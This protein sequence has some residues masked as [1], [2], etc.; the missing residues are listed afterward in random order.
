[1]KNYPKIKS[2][3]HRKHIGEAMAKKVWQVII[4]DKDGTKQTIQTKNLT[5]WCKENN[6]DNSNL[7]KTLIYEN[8]KVHNKDKTLS[9]SLLSNITVSKTLALVT[10]SKTSVPITVSKNPTVS[11]TPK[12]SPVTVS[13]STDPMITSRD[14]EDDIEDTKEY[15]RLD[16]AIDSIMDNAERTISKREIKEYVENLTGDLEWYDKDSWL[17]WLKVN[18]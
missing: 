8:R 5:E 14:E 13:R 18:L 1:M 4:T 2:L 16:K 11:R 17:H 15:K 7:L 12:P 9:Y 6:V 3:E 10:V